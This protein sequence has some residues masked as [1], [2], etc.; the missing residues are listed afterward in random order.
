MTRET[1]RADVRDK[2]AA[3][4]TALREGTCCGPTDPKVAGS[5]LYPELGPD[6][7]PDLSLLGSLGCGNPTAVA[8]LRVGEKVLDLGSGG[9]LDVILSARRVGATGKAYGVDALEEMLE[10]ARDNAREAGVENVEFLDGMLDDVPLP[11]GSI[12]VVI[13]NCVV[14]LVE[15]KSAVF[16]EMAR[17]I[18]SGGRIG[19][20]DVVAE[21]ELTPTD[22]A[23]RGS[24]ADCIAGALS[25]AEYRALL[26]E[27]GFTE[28]DITFT[29]E[30]AEQMHGAIIKARR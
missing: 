13:S 19:L 7:V 5:T 9:G 17:L 23:N 2:Y 28:V 4:A 3:A 8:D 21:D 6:V 26:E 10:L 12:D 14:N 24:Y 29:H 16:T 25:R 18:R 22:R 27:A 1:L 30:V 20:S 11:D 15:D